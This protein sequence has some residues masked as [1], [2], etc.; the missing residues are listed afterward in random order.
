[1]RLTAFRIENYRC[2][3][4]SGW[5][6]IDDIGVIVGKNESGKTSLLKG[7][8][9]FRPFKDEPYNLK[10]EWPRGR[11]KEMSEDKVVATVRFQ[12]TPEEITAIEGIHD[13]AKGITGVEI[14]RNYGGQY[15]HNFTPQNPTDTHDLLWVVN[16][17]TKNLGQPGESF[18]EHFKTQYKTAFATLLAGVKDN[19]GSEYAVKE[20][21]N[22][23]NRLTSF[24][25]PHNP[26][27]DHQAIPKLEQI[28]D[29]TVNEIATTPMQRVIDFIHQRMPTFVYMDDYLTFR[30]M[31]Q[32]DEIL[33][34][35]RRGNLKDD[36]ETIIVIMEM[37]G[38]KLEEE[39]Q[40][41]NEEDR[42]QRILDMNDASQTLTRLISDRWSQRKY[43]VRF[44]ADGQHFK[45][46]IGR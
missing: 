3:Q 28:I 34:R 26:Q 18:T 32:L 43:E 39:V 2:I 35:Q 29:A 37:A 33:E 13:S 7:L 40:K 1:M 36:D 24:V 42:E 11:R 23:K 30:G 10:R 45:Y 21:P 15:I 19:G 20:L 27:Q 44:Q 31:A 12:F 46:T 4:D 25:L 22:L 16:L 14:K 9:K 38:L 8:W 5:V 17:L 41:G 6:A